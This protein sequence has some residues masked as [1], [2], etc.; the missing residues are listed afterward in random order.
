[1]LKILM[2][3][4]MKQILVIDMIQMMLKMKWMKVNQ[5]RSK[6]MMLKKSLMTKLIRPHMENQLLI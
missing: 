2:M 3:I 4:S 6:I 5:M 1:M